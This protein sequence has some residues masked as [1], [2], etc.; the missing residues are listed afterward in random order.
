MTA[1][2]ARDT[3]PLGLRGRAEDLAS[4]LPPLLAEAEQ[5]AQ[6]VLMG[7]HGRRRAGAGSNFWQYRA[8]QPHDTARAIDWRRSGR[9][10]QA[11][12]QEKEWQI[13]QSVALWVDD[14]ASMGFASTPKLPPKGDRARLISLALAVVLNRGGER[15]GL[16]DARLPPRRG[17]G[18]LSRLAQILS[19][20]AEADHG[21]PEP[22]S[23][24]PRSRA[25]LVSDFLG[26]VEPIETMLTASADRG[27]R[28]ALLQ[29]L[30]PAEEAFPYDGRT[31][32]ESMSGAIRHE[33]LKAGELRDR[34]LDRL[35]ERRDR[36]GQLAR[37][38]GWQFSTHRTGDSAASALLWLYAALERR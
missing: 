29:V 36:L 37:V 33:T 18:Q 3:T 17:R 26:P 4:P 15:V 35:A 20:S 1:D 30:D 25:V 27:V 38:T 8:A 10:D 22:R 28:G 16:A 2:P 5:L 32:F 6:T 24:A 23:L 7:E 9:A 21:V 31:I 13:A 14:G 19:H 34:Y 11:F 12:V